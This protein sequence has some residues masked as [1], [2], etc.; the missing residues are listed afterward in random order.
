MRIVNF[1]ISISGSLIFAFMF[2]VYLYRVDIKM[3]EKQT[4]VI[5]GLLMIFSVIQLVSNSIKL[6]K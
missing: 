2:V 6:F 5:L 1:I 3:V 4:K